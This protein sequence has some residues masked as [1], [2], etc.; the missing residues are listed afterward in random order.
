MSDC[1]Q[2]EIRKCAADKPVSASEMCPVRTK[3]NLEI[4]PRVRIKQTVMNIFLKPVILF[5]QFQCVIVTLNG[6]I[7]MY[8]NLVLSYLPRNSGDC[9]FRHDLS[10]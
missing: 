7:Y 5:R 3:A 10:C 8:V 1:D 9:N 4:D 6:E 2:M